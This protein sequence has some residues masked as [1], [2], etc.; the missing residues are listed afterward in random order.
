MTAATAKRIKGGVLKLVIAI[1]SVVNPSVW[2]H[3]KKSPYKN[4]HANF[5]AANANP[6]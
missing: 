6:P 1:R 2:S 4:W 3:A 5:A